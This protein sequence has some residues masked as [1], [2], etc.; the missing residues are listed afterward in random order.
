MKEVNLKNVAK[1][2]KNG[3]WSEAMVDEAVEAGKLTEAEANKIKKLPVK[4]APN[5]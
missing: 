3:L 4:G 2:F 5:E 1:W